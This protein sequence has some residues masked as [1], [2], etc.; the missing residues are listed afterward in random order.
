MYK[1]IYKQ[2]FTHTCVEYNSMHFGTGCL[3]RMWPY[4]PKLWQIFSVDFRGSFFYFRYIGV[5]SYCSHRDHCVYADQ[6]SDQTLSASGISQLKSNEAIVLVKKQ[7]EAIVLV[8]KI[9]PSEALSSLKQYKRTRHSLC[10][11]T[12]NVISN[13][14]EYKRTDGP[15]RLPVDKLQYINLPP[16]FL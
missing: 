13:T 16:Y 2:T 8:I 11:L 1:S 3:G 12:I 7:N 14:K 10:L 15:T 6:Q 4:Y 9:K 5:S